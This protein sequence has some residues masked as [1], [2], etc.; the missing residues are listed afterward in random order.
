VET[1]KKDWQSWRG[2][3]AAD[4]VDG[5]YPEAGDAIERLLKNNPKDG[6]LSP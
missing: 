3:A 2:L 1:N 4:I 6:K 5:R